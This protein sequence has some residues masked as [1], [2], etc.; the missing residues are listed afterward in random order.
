MSVLELVSR[1]WEGL[2]RRIDSFL[3]TA[4]MAIVLVG[5]VTLYSATDQSTARI[6]SQLMS[7]AFA[8]FLMWI[9]ANIAPE[10]L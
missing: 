1:A 8:L 3:F 9:V 7:L 6:E 4:A 2:T 5:L 10:K